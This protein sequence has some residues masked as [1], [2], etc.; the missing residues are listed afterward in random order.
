MSRCEGLSFVSRI[1]LRVI[2]A[3]HGE[4]VLIDLAVHLL[5]ATALVLAAGKLH[6]H[7]SAWRSTGLWAL[8]LLELVL[9]APVWLVLHARHPEWFFLYLAEIESLGWLHAR[10]Q[11]VVAG[12][13]IGAYLGGRALM[14]RGNASTGLILVAVTPLISGL[15]IL[16]GWSRSGWIGS[17]E[18]L[19]AGETMRPLFETSEGYLLLGAVTASAL[20]T[21]FVCWR[22]FIYARALPLQGRMGAAVPVRDGQTQALLEGENASPASK[23]VRPVH[24]SR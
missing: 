20:G 23:Q 1:I 13:T 7:Q 9:L 17:T 21:F 10:G 15:L 4:Y 8:I 12:V 5:V 16:A 6:A 22:V 2:G 3:L 19:I 24:T 18:A 14:L 11:L